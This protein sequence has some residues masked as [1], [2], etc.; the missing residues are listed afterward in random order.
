MATIGYG[1]DLIPLKDENK[2]LLASLYPDSQRYF[3]LHHSVEDTLDKI[4]PRELQ[5][6]SAA[7]ASLLYMI[8]QYGL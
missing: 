5:L 4:N 8:D 3:D 2:T 6:G 7:M 1:I